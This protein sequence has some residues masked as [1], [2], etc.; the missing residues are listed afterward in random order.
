MEAETVIVATTD[1]GEQLILPPA[2]FANRF[3]W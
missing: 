2:G 1:A 3:G